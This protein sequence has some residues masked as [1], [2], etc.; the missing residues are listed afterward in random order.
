[1]GMVRAY[2][3]ARAL[4]YSDPDLALLGTS[5]AACIV[6]TLILIDSS[7]F[8]LGLEKGFFVLAGF[9][10]AFAA[11]AKSTPQKSAVLRASLLK[12]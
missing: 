6:G 12:E 8:I 1:L 2:S 11:V 10:A 3:R 4:S 5:I 7:S 9:A